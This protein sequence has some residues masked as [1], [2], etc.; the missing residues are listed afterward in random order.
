MGKHV[1][2][3]WSQCAITET[4]QGKQGGVPLIVGTRIPAQQ[5]VEE[6]DLG[7]DVAEIAENYPSITVSRI[8]F[9]LDYAKLHK[10]QPVP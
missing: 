3:D 2:I 9:L 4:I 6:H 10:M 7:S 1:Q 5:I 8:Q